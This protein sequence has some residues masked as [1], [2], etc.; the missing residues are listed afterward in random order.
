VEV[1]LHVIYS[2]VHQEALDNGYVSSNLDDDY[3]CPRIES[4]NYAV[5]QNTKTRLVNNIYFGNLFDAPDLYFGCQLINAS[6]SSELE[7]YNNTF[8]GLESVV[9]LIYHGVNEPYYKISIDNN[10]VSKS[11]SLIDNA[12]YAST[13][14]SFTPESSI[15]LNNNLVNEVNS[16]YIDMQDQQVEVNTLFADPLLDSNGYP[17]SNSPAIDAG[18]PLKV[19]V[20]LYGVA[21]P[22]DGDNNGTKVID[23]GAIEFRLN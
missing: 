10:I 13:L 9:K 7:V 12:S 21:R 23:I 8:L 16:L 15:S 3:H 20:D 22:I 11:R 17:F 1:L 6:M 5:A 2:M 19:D 14:Y 18:A 4:G